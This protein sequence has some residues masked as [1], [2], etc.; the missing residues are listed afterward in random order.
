MT[1]E[2]EDKSRPESEKVQATISLDWRWAVGMVL[3]LIGSAAGVASVYTILISGWI[4]TI[5]KNTTTEIREIRQRLNK[6]N[7]YIMRISRHQGVLS[8]TLGSSP[9]GGQIPRSDKLEPGTVPVISSGNG[10]AT[11]RETTK[12]EAESRQDP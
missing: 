6:H 3:T 12:I 7:D 8:G 1:A 4:D 10:E 2:V 11:W 9:T 5:D